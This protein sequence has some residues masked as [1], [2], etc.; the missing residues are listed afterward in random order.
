MLTIQGP[1]LELM[2][3]VFNTIVF[4]NDSLESR[5]SP[6]RAPFLA[7]GYPLFTSDDATDL[8]VHC[9]E[10]GRV[11]VLLTALSKMFNIQPKPCLWYDLWRA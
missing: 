5:R 10:D 2:K 9:R 1:D 11:Y 7:E 3:A 8:P 4:E 6:Y